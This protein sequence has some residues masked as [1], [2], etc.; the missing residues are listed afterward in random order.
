LIATGYEQISRDP[1]C[2]F[3]DI[4]DEQGVRN[5]FV[6]SE[7]DGNRRVIEPA[8]PRMWGMEVHY[9]LGAYR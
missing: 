6:Y 9:K 8:N 3:S 1:L 4:T 2:F 5:Q 7:I